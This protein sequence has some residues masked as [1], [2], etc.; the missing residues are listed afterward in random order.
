MGKT[1]IRLKFSEVAPR[2]MELAGIEKGHGQEVQL[3]K[4][5]GIAPQSL[6]NFEKR[7]KLPT[8]RVLLF[9][10]KNNIPIE[11]VIG[12]LLGDGKEK[13]DGKRP[14]AHRAAEIDDAGKKEEVPKKDAGLRR[15]EEDIYYSNVPALRE[16][17]P[18]WCDGRQ[19]LKLFLLKPAF[20]PTCNLDKLQFI[21]QEESNF[22]P[23]IPTGTIL[24]V[25]THNHKITSA[26]YLFSYGVGSYALRR[27]DPVDEH[28][29]RVTAGLSP[30]ADSRDMT[31]EQVK[32]LIVGRVVWAV[33]KI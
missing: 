24:V 19:I 9:C 33:Y 3:A 18:E 30:S 21:V 4:A 15:R 8:D 32:P 14:D 7:D 25:D 28:T 26:L 31:I 6:T 11:K 5:L 22:H 29:V 2:L 17:G 13:R 23:T 27:I 20:G 1:A 16:T 10:L 12:G